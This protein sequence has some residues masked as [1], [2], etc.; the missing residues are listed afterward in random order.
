MS[1]L[2]P[3]FFYAGLIAAAGAIALH[4]IVMRQPPSDML[5]T[6]RFIPARPAVARTV[7]KVPEDLLLLLTRIAAMVLIGAAFARPVL[8]PQRASIL[9]I[10]IADRSRA[11]ADVHEV[12]DSVGH[13]FGAHAND[14]SSILVLAD[15]SAH[16]ITA[17]IADSLKHLQR[18]GARGAISAALITAIR[19]GSRI[20]DLADS[21]DI[22][23]VSP[24][25]LD[26]M[27]VATDSIRA[28]WPGQIRAIRVAAYKDSAAANAS[29]ALVNWPADGH[30][31]DAGARNPVD[32]ARA[33][34]AGRAVL[35]AEMPRRWQFDSTQLRVAGTE[36]IARWADGEPAAIERSTA[37]GCTRDVVVP[38]PVAGDL[39]LR[40]EYQ[41]FTAVFDAP[42]GQAL[43]SANP[44]IAP[45]VVDSAMPRH[46]A[47][48]ALAD[49]SLAPT[50]LTKWCL[51]LGLLVLLIEL[52]VRR[53]Y[54]AP[55]RAQA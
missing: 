41:R 9:H 1:F 22:T 28:V 12:A 36:V 26:E 42:C 3:A 21:V 4:F 55:T 14:K 30:A 47:T 29:H 45:W 11:V 17:H 13:I 49:A 39:M 37:G 27:D 19:T 50:L 53:I 38:K 32:T 40:P 15:S 7:N 16:E 10:V 18:V 54:A 24:L 43:R 34:I 23:V 8:H 35:V 51:G 31:P 46:I 25:T 20:H 48:R 44:V 33:V 6:T 2:A 52:L 5:P